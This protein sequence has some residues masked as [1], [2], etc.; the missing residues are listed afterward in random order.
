MYV[1][2]IVPAPFIEEYP[3]SVAMPSHLCQKLVDSVWL[4]LFLGYFIPSIN[5][6]ILSPLLHCFDYCDFMVSLGI[7]QS[8]FTTVLAILVPVTFRINFR[9]SLS[10]FMKK[11]W[12]LIGVVFHVQI[13]PWSVLDLV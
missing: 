8:D 7:E 12:I 5:E 13:D 10:L 9:I 3:F 11:P 1:C 4:N 6:S 2:P